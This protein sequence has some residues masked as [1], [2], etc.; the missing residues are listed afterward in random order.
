MIAV[1][2]FIQGVPLPVTAVASLLAAALF[3][4]SAVKLT[5][6]ER[7][8]GQLIAWT[9]AGHALFFTVIG[10]SNT[11]DTF[12]HLW[13]YGIATPVTIILIYM[14]VSTGK[15]MAVGRSARDPGRRQHVSGV[16]VSRAG[17]SDFYGPA[18]SEGSSKP[19]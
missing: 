19:A 4:S 6:G 17:L 16:P 3:A 13:K 15:T 5:A 1:S 7:D 9:A 12:E 10:T 18:D 2:A 14:A 8:A 11:S